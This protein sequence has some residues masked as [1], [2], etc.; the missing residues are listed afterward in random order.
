[1]QYFKKIKMNVKK[2]KNMK[3]KILNEDRSNVMAKAQ[4]MNMDLW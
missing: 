3:D 4:V 2:A 1:M